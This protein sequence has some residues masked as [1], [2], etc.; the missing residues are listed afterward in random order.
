MFAA[1]AI[2]T[3]FIAAERTDS[4]E[5][6]PAVPIEGEP[7][8]AELLSVDD[9][10]NIV[11]SGA[12]EK[13]T[14]PAAR[15]VRW[16]A[17]A[18]I[19]EK[20]SLVLL[21]DGGLIAADVIEMGKEELLI[22]S[23]LWGEVRLPL[24][25][26][27]GIVFWPPANQLQ[28]NRLVDR[29]RAAEGQDDR[30]LLENGDS[31]DG[32]LESLSD[33]SIALTAKAG[34]IEIPLE[35]VTAVIFNPALVDPPK[36]APLRALVGFRDGTCIT[37]EKL[38]VGDGN[39]QLALPGGVKLA[40]EPD[41]CVARELVFLMPF[42]PHVTYLSDIKPIGYKHI[43]FLDLPWSYGTDR[44]VLGGRLRAG[45]RLHAKGLGMHSTSRLAYQLDR[46]YKK[47][48]ASL[49]I[50]D[51]QP[52]RGSV[53]FRVYV[54]DESGKFTPA[55]TSPILRGGDAP[56]PISVDIT[57]AKRIA[58]IVDFADRGDELDHA[59]WLDARLVK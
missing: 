19:P 17:P 44:N 14:L 23:D 11:F 48:A 58:L 57:G 35:K 8:Q 12:A 49:A 7:F 4:G 37:A 56:L 43:P 20:G 25:L 13:R 54:G 22:G 6:A 9:Q 41:V 18:P 2:L 42:G 1:A 15:L 28:R 5:T 53:T 55:L 39:A 27:E 46:P 59:D 33:R 51:H 40:N 29:V 52:G 50:D 34:K 26:L 45:G 3:I 24:S 16:G 32:V 10:W 21:A 38:I 47:F 30:L 31:I 36:T